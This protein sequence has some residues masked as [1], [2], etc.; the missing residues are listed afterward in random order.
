MRPTADLVSET[1]GPDP[2][3]FS[4]CAGS[5]SSTASTESAASSEAA[6]ASLDSAGLATLATDAAIDAAWVGAATAVTAATDDGVLRD[7]KGNPCSLSDVAANMLRDEAGNII[8]PPSWRW[9]GRAATST[10]TAPRRG[11]G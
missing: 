2:Y 3:F 10:S 4:T 6:A 7:D 9:A 1:K 8:D 11:R 5:T